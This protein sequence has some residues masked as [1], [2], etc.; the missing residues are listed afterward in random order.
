M[1]TSYNIRVAAQN[2]IGLST[3][4]EALPATTH[5]SITKPVIEGELKIVHKSVDGCTLEWQ[6]ARQSDDTPI[7]GYDV[8]YKNVNTQKWCKFNDDLVLSP[9]LR[10]YGLALGSTYEFKVEAVNAANLRSDACLSTEHLTLA[11]DTT[12]MKAH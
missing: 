10:L 9:I 7:D 2:K 5:C 6:E 8:F 1:A 11:S 4:E 3:F 12:G